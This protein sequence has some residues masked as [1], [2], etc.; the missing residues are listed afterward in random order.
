M[1]LHLLQDSKPA[2]LLPWVVDKDFLEDVARPEDLLGEDVK[3]QVVDS[4]VL[5]NAVVPHLAQGKVDEVDVAPLVHVV[6]PKVLHSS[7]KAGF[8]PGPIWRQPKQLFVG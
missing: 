7:H 2:L 1:V 8:V 5:F 3:Q 6:L 4:Q